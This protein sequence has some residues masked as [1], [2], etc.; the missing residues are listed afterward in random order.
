MD[1]LGFRWRPVITRRNRCETE[2]F[3]LFMVSKS[4]ISKSGYFEPNVLT[5][6]G[7]KI[8]I[9]QRSQVERATMHLPRRSNGWKSHWVSLED[10]LVRKKRASEKSVSKVTPLNRAILINER[11]AV[12]WSFW[13]M[14]QNIDSSVNL[15]DQKVTLFDL[16]QGR[17]L[18]NT[19]RVLQ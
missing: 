6:S 9:N 11:M 19:S 16:R 18:I 14:Y 7:E 3:L 15:Q 4:T 5:S 1:D 12:T 2:F 13:A 8:E 10:F 17:L